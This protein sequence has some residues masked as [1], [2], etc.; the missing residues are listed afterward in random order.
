MRILIIGGTI[1]LGRHIRE[2]ALANGHA[3]TIFHRGQH[4]LGAAPNIQEILGDRENP[5]DLARLASGHWDAIIDTCAYVPRQ[6]RLL[7]SA[8]ATSQAR[9]VL[10]STISVYPDDTQP[11]AD[12]TFPVAALPP[13]ADENQRSIELYGPLKARC[14]AAVRAW[15]PDRG[16][17][18]R[19]GLIVGPYDP[20]DRFTYWPRRIAA[21]GEVLAP[22]RPA[23][24]VQFIDVRDLAGWTIRAV[25][26]S[27]TGT[28]NAT[29]P[30]N[31]LSMGAMLSTT[32]AALQSDAT[33]T[34]VEDRFLLESHIAPWAEL[35]LW[36]PE[37]EMPGLMTIN[38]SRAVAAGLTFRALAATVS[39]TFA[40]DRQRP[41]GTPAGA[42][43]AATKERAVLA[44]WHVRAH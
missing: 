4:A 34:W 5:T 22:G 37:P 15:L 35:P 16:L 38:N 20:T 25:E 19:P 43:L 8:F 7:Q 17:I 27:L 28:Y 10:I 12:E 39:D 14:E 11:G 30:A 3:V 18:I 6:I 32:T 23:R 44:N 36:I 29:G 21:G 26:S 31:E 42:G 1:F 9:Y 41:A 13:T 33:F 24:A 2:V 40:W